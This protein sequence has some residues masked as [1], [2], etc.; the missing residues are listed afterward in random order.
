MGFG[1]SWLHPQKTGNKKRK[2]LE[3]NKYLM[4]FWVYSIE[5]TKLTQ[6]P[7]TVLCLFCVAV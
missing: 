2:K 4:A 1:D 6:K 7:L 3:Q 5:G